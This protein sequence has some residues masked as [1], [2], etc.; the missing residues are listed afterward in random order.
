MERKSKKKK[1]E[2]KME[3]QELEYLQNERS[4]LGEK[5]SFIVFEGLSF[6]EK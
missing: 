3:I 1:K 6:D 5:T 4:F 2:V